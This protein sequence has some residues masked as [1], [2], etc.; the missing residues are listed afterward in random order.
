[1]PSYKTNQEINGKAVY[2]DICF[3][4]TKEFREKLYGSVLK[5]YEEA[6]SKVQAEAQQTVAQSQT[7]KTYDGQTVP[8][9]DTP[10]R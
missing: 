6:K 7:V 10:F 2:Q 8:K 1:M 5:A 9:E 3:P 4:V